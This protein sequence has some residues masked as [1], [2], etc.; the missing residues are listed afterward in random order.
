MPWCLEPFAEGRRRASTMGSCVA[1]QQQAPAI[2]HR[3]DSF[4]ILYKVPLKIIEGK[5]SIYLYVEQRGRGGGHEWGEGVVGGEVVVVVVEEAD[6]LNSWER[7]R[8]GF[9]DRV[10]QS[11]RGSAGCVAEACFTFLCLWWREIPLHRLTH[12]LPTDRWFCLI[13]DLLCGSKSERTGWDGSTGSAVPRGLFWT[14][15]SLLSP[16]HRWHHGGNSWKMRV[17]GKYETF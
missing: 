4:F 1:C 5:K 13:A 14:Y 2:L 10:V 12:T 16:S 15:S 17:L 8:I 11:W 3:Y 6:V 9:H 7:R